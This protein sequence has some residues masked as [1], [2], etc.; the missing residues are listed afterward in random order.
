MEKSG[1]KMIKIKL[2]RRLYCTVQNKIDRATLKVFDNEF[3]RELKALQL[4]RI[5]RKKT[6]CIDDGKI[7]DITPFLKLY[8]ITSSEL[9]YKLYFNVTWSLGDIIAKGK[10]EDMENRRL[11][12]F[13]QTSTA[14]EIL[15]HHKYYVG[16]LEDVYFGMKFR[17]TI[18]ENQIINIDRFDQNNNQLGCLSL[19]KTLRDKISY[20]GY[21]SIEKKQTYAR[22][23]KLC[24]QINPQQAD[25]LCHKFIENV[26]FKHGDIIIDLTNLLN[27]YY[28]K[29]EELFLYLYIYTNSKKV[30]T[31]PQATKILQQNNYK[32]DIYDGVTIKNSFRLS[33]NEQ[34]IINIFQYELNGGD[35]YSAILSLLNSKI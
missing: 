34:Q 32:I 9:L 3:N 33:N 18:D 10:W 28:I 8:R 26:Q 4:R 6:K 24:L 11:N 15:N 1:I 35:F 17:K 7:M 20:V 13:H 12:I 30:L 23:K 19:V 14:D 5:F 16:Q 27:I 25:N 2:C 21:L 22:I 31:L 29:S